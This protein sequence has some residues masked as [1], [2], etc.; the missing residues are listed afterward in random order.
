MKV[1]KPS[2]VPVWANEPTAEPQLPESTEPAATD[3][4]AQ[5]AMSDLEWMRQRMSQNVDVEE[6]VFEQSDDEDTPKPKKIEPVSFLGSYF[7]SDSS[8]RLQEVIVAD[9]TASHDATK[10]DTTID[11][12]KSTI[13]QTSRLFVRNLAFS[14]TDEELAELFKPF[15]EIS[16]V[17]TAFPL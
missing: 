10:H 4:S 11:T 14:C 17:S 13:L 8:T 12:T 16:Q 7:H 9:P 3:S 1:M 15:G 5:G 2:K 6:R